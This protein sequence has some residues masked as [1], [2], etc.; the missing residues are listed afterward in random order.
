MDFLVLAKAA[1]ALFA[2][3]DPVGVIPIFLSATL[4]FSETQRGRAARVAAITVIVILAVFTFVGEPLLAFFN[5]RQSHSM[6]K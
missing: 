5:I 4:G 6:S 2:I 3:V 1:L